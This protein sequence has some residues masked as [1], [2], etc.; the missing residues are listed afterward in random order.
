MK[1][2]VT[3][4]ILIPIAALF[5]CEKN[6]KDDYN[7]KLKIGQNFEYSYNDFEL[8][9]SSTH[10]LYFKTAHPE[11]TDQKLSD[12]RFYSDSTIFYQGTYWPGYSSSWPTGPFIMKSPFFYPDYII[13]FE[14][15]G[16]GNDPRNDYRLMSAF[17]DHNLLHSGL[18]GEIKEIAINGTQLTFSFKVTNKDQSELLI[19]DPEKTGQ[20]LFHYFTNAPVF[21]NLSQ[22]KLYEYDFEHDAPPDLNAWSLTWL[23][24]LRP[25]E[26]KTFTFTYTTDILFPAGDYKVSFEFPGLSHQISRG[27]LYQDN[28][29]IW[30]GDITMTKYL[31]IQ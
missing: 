23:T 9:D 31:R 25:E 3:I 26:S 8:Y 22:N 30:L 21:Y 14:F 15:M 18:S 27:Q 16:P 12:F 20:K 11:L 4:L 10:M 1:T 28:K 24:E 7:L 29:R 2:P 17:S 13:R 6:G 5:S 19:L